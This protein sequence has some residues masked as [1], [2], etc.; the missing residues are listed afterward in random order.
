MKR[1]LA[2]SFFLHCLVIGWAVWLLG[3]P[4]AFDVA[5]IEALPVTLI[6]VGEVTQTQLGEETAELTDTPAPVPTKRPDVVADAEN[7]GENDIDLDTQKN[8]EAANVQEEA[9]AP[10]KPSETVQNDVTP[11]EAAPPP[12]PERAPTPE[13]A[14]Q[15]PAEPEPAPPTPAPKPEPA[16][17]P[18][19]PA[20]V[21][22]PE[23][24][25]APEPQVAEQQAE[26][27]EE[28]EELVFP[29]Q[30]P[31]P[32]RRPPQQQPQQQVAQNRPETPANRPAAASTS[33]DD[34]DFNVDEIAALLN[35]TEAQGG[36]AARSQAEQSLGT[37]TSSSSAQLSQSELDALRGQIQRNWSILAGLDGSDGVRIRI[38]MQLD[39][40]GAIIGSPEVT[41]TGGTENARNILASGARRAVLKASPFTQLPPEKYDSWREVIV[42]FDPSQML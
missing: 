21:E 24:A 27:A 3:S 17:A 6:P 28:Q 13:P 31:L 34:N 37:Q 4:T 39:Q 5:D 8:A 26:A 20:A 22:T 19:A 40:N 18:P 1:S 12:I 9:A 30:A 25:P 15:P 10:P 16:P 38:H 11:D 42:N 33:S 29:D 2:I 36:G 7:V 23:P 32:S 14:P 41:A 35:R